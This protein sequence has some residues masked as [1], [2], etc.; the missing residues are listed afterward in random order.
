[1]RVLFATAALIAAIGAGP[2]YAQ[3]GSG[4]RADQSVQPNGITSNS[5]HMGNTA[6]SGPS[7]NVGSFN[8]AKIYD[9]TNGGSPHASTGEPPAGPAAAAAPKGKG[10]APR[11]A[12]NPAPNSNGE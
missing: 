9:I 8:D 1:M 11:S 10:P 12:G 3:S 6:A 4:D 5:A 2:L 7:G